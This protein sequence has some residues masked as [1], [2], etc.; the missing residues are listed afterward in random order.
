[1]ASPPPGGKF[2]PLARVHH[3]P[4]MADTLRASG[5]LSAAIFGSRVL[6]LVREVVFAALFGAGALADAFFVAFRF[7]NLLRDLLA[8]GA[9]SSAFVPTFT[10]TRENEGDAAAHALAD[11]VSSLLLILTGT[12]A[13]LGI[14]FSEALVL[15]FA[16]GFAAD[17]DKLELASR[18]TRVM[19]PI[20]AL[21]SLGAVWM[22]MLNA[23]RRFVIPALGPA[24]FNVVSLVAGVVIAIATLDPVDGIL[25]WSAG[26][27]MAGLTQAGSQLFVLVRAGYRPRIRVR[28]CLAHPGVRRIATLMAPATIG[29][30]AVQINVLVNQD[31]LSE[32]GDGA[33]AAYNLAFRIFFLPLGVFGVA[34]GT[35]TLTSVSQAAA[36]GDTRKVAQALGESLSAGAM[37]ISASAVGLLVLAEPI[38]T[39]LYRHGQTTTDDAA[40][41]ALVLQA[42]ALGLL[43]YGLIKIVAPA[44]YSLDQPRVPLLAS[45]LGVALNIGFNAATYRILGAPGIALGTA[46]GAA[47]N[48]LV[49]RI[50]VARRIGALEETGRLRRL[51]ALVIANVAM[52]GIVA[53]L[54]MLARDGLASSGSLP[55]LVDTALLGLVLGMLV[56]LGFVV[57][58]GVLRTFGYPGAAQLWS[59]PR[60]LASRLRRRR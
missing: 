55:H 49:L 5:G 39:F 15:A 22:G 47:L 54:W 14:L 19:M 23:R 7:P 43:P 25:V 12:L 32:L 56:T 46:L 41:I 18:L 52:G 1:M 20:V 11:R 40:L 42:F 48:L 30:A 28:G 10:A 3:T 53:G 33:V 4:G 9:L 50:M 35:V 8:E 17:P 27:L 37:L 13:I 21:V 6:G 31:F 51:G 36:G 59:L 34:L 57:Y 58:V 16:S 2:G 26:T 45:V 44:F 29:L 38:V 60:R 24:L